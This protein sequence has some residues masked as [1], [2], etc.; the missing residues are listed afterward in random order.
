MLQQLGVDWGKLAVQAIN[1]L[2][3]LYLLHRM[4]YRPL[5]RMMDQRRERIRNDLE[6]ARR[7]REEAERT[8]NLYHEQLS[9]ARD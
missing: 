2:I 1:F 9:R 4:A 8:R 6:E 7:L 5:L 3:L